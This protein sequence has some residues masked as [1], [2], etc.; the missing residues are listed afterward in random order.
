[1]LATSD[2]ARILEVTRRGRT[3]PFP[4]LAALE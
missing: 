3:L 1:M 4:L 2:S